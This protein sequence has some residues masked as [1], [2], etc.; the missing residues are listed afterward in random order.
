[1]VVEV[2]ADHLHAG[3]PERREVTA[4]HVEVAAQRRVGLEMHTRLDLGRSGAL[5]LQTALDRAEDLLVRQCEP[6]HVGLGEDDK[7]T[8][9]H[10]RS[11]PHD[12]R[13]DGLGLTAEQVVWVARDRA[14]VELDPAARARMAEARAVVER[15]LA[16]GRP[17]YGLTTGLGSR[18]VESLPGEEQAEFSRL[19]VLGRAHSVGPPLPTEVVRAAMLVRANGLA[20]R[21]RR[22]R[23]YSSRCSNGA[24]I[25]SSRRSARSAPATSA[26]S[27]TSD[28][29]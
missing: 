12:L 3:E 28:S 27:R 4:Q 8:R 16:D 18:V 19:T 6:A 11:T 21:A 5:C 24:F 13:L 20:R 25:P 26:C 29:C 22:S 10:E 17:A 9:L 7:L 2:V 14:R 1:M 23:S 15:Y